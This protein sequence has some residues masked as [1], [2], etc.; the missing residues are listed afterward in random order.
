MVRADILLFHSPN[1]GLKGSTCRLKLFPPP[2]RKLLALLVPPLCALEE[3]VLIVLHVVT[4][5]ITVR[6]RGVLLIITRHD[7]LVLVGVLLG[8]RY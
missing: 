4:G 6:R 5:K 1:F 8:S 7:M 3:K 2:T